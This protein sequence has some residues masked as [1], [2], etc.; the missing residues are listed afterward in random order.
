MRFYPGALMGYIESKPIGQLNRKHSRWK[1]TGVDEKEWAATK[2]RL[3][4]VYQQARGI[5]KDLE[6][7]KDEDDIGATIVLLVPTTS[8][9][10]PIR[11]VPRL[12]S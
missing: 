7:R 12:V 4:T 9:P 11:Q 2:Q 10:G 3:Q 1:S 8:H 5:V 6:G